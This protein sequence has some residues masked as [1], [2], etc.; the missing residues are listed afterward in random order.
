MNNLLNNLLFEEIKKNAPGFINV[1]PIIEKILESE[2]KPTNAFFEHAIQIEESW[3]LSDT[4]D[5]RIRAFFGLPASTHFSS[6]MFR[7]NFLQSVLLVALDQAIDPEKGCNGYPV[8]IRNSDLDTLGFPL[9]TTYEINMFGELIKMMI[10][11]LS[12]TAFGEG[13]RKDETYFAL[14]YNYGNI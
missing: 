12:I 2:N 14:Y 3:I 7:R 8:S 5:A 10:P 1:F 6:T 9:K 11:R 13:T 4:T